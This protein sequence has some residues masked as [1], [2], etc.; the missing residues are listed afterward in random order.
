MT[1]LSDMHSIQTM[2]A[3]KHAEYGLPDGKERE[4]SRASAGIQRRD[5]E[6]A[7]QRAECPRA[8]RSD[9]GREGAHQIAPGVQ[10]SSGERARISARS[11]RERRGVEERREGRRGP[12][13]SSRIR[14]HRVQASSGEEEEDRK[15]R[16]EREERRETSLGGGE[17]PG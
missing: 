9:R 15:G 1:K 5:V 16:S 2:F 4:S 11:A 13:A 17:K 12:R 3:S 10:A 7:R 8:A 6:D 14:E